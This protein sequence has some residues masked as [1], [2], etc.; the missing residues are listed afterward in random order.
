VT[1]VG[2]IHHYVALG[3]ITRFESFGQIG[4]F[5]HR[6]LGPYE[7]LLQ[8]PFAEHVIRT[9]WNPLPTALLW[10][11]Y[12]ADHFGLLLFAA[13]LVGSVALVVRKRREGVFWWAW[14]GLAYLALSVQENWDVPNKMGVIYVLFHPFVIWAAFGLWISIHAPRT[15]GVAF[16]AVALLSGFGLHSLR[17]LDVPA[18]TRYYEHWAGER[19]EDPAYVRAELLRITDV[20]PWP[21]YGR[22]GPFSRV[23]EWQKVSGLV[24]DLQ[25]PSIDTTGTPYGWFPGESTNLNQSVAIELDLSQ[26]LFDRDPNFVRRLE[27]S[28]TVDVDL[29]TPGPPVVIPNIRVSWTSRPVSVLFSRG[30]AQVTGVALIFEEWPTRERPVP[31]QEAESFEVDPRRC[32]L[33]DRYHRGLMMVLGWEAHDLLQAELVHVGGSRVSIRGPGGPISIVES[34]NNAGQNYLIWRAQLHPDEAVSLQGPHR[35]FHN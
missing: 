28:A 22:L 7:G 9:P 33:W 30:Q 32:T 12:L 8:W 19:E 10:P 29:S 31:C 34:V 18:D 35:V 23:F 1:L 6:F 15:W 4:P 26:R 16:V 14:I 5:P 11:A 24:A 27:D 2:H 13:M 3:S 20:D 21:D 25:D 17:H